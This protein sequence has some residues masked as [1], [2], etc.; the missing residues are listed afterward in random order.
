MKKLLTLV[1]ALTLMFTSCSKDEEQVSVPTLAPILVTQIVETVEYGGNSQTYTLGFNY[2]GNK[3]ISQTRNGVEISNVIYEG[4]LIKQINYLNNGSV[5]RENVYTYDTSERL[6]TFHQIEYDNI[7]GDYESVFN[8]TYNSDGTVSYTSQSGYSPNLNYSSSGTINFNS[9]GLIY[10][11]ETSYGKTTTYTYDNKNS[12]LKNIL[13]VNKIPFEEGVANPMFRNYLSKVE[14]D[15]FGT[16][17]TNYTH[18][19]N[20]NNYP[21]QSIEDDNSEKFTRVYTYNQ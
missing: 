20:S 6:V 7:S 12:P 13:G 15:N 19:Y 4:N 3:L 8:Y 1:S 9:D 16:Y 21:I 10:Q 14:V 2:N 18:T 11:V 17:T 5:V